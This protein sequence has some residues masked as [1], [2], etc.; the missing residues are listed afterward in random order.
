MVNEAQGIPN[1]P[2]SGGTVTLSYGEKQDKR[3][4]KTETTF[5]ELPP[6]MRNKQAHLIYCSASGGGDR[7]YRNNLFDRDFLYGAR[8]DPGCTWNNNAYMDNLAP[9]Q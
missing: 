9:V 4:I 2:F 5:K 7:I 8:T 3:E 6:G 1:L